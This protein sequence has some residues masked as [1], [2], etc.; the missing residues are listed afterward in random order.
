MRNINGLV[1]SSH[2]PVRPG[3]FMHLVTSRNNSHQSA[4]LGAAHRLGPLT[5]LHETALQSML[6]YAVSMRQA[7]LHQA[8]PALRE[9]E[10]APIATGGA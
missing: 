5:L 8:M 3:H 7:R 10:A 6:A 1:I 2:L 4:F 9:A